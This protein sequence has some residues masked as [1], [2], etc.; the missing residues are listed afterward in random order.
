MEYFNIDRMQFHQTLYTSDLIY[1]MMVLDG[2]RAVNWVELTQDF[3]NLVRANLNLVND[4]DILIYDREY[5]NGEE[6]SYDSSNDRH[7]GQYGW[8]YDFTAFYNSDHQNY[9][10]EGIILPSVTPAV[11]ELKNPKI[12]IRGI[13]R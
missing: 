3:N 7:N 4:D 5:V 8:R 11:F 1:E 2:V 12:N 10:G 9:V 6:A 13:V